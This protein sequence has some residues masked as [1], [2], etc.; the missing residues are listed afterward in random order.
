[1]GAA[2]LKDP[3]RLC[4]I[5]R[6]LVEE[7]GQEHEIGISVKIRLL[8]T[9]EQTRVL[10][11]R[12]VKTGI[13]ALTVHCR[14]TPMRPREKAIRDHLQ[15]IA[16]VC[17]EAG[18]ACVMNGDVE[19]REQAHTLMEE[20]GVDGAMIASAAEKNP[21]CFRVAEEGGLLDWRE[22]VDEYVRTALEVHNKW[23]NTKYLLGQMIPGK[24]S[25]YKLVTQCKS[26]EA[27]V[28]ALQMHALAEEA[29]QVDDA[30]QIRPNEPTAGRKK[31]ANDAVKRGK[32]AKR[33]KEDV[34]DARKAPSIGGEALGA[35]PPQT[36]PLE[37]SA[38]ALSA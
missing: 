11:E 20:Y 5:L 13:A 23:G 2:L 6:A 28:W 15:M 8:E 16:G 10:V 24:Q 35:S 21:S 3:D 38:A 7:V 26:Y 32:D 17:R 4:A 37:M 12:L 9:E 18:V 36:L 29:R 25:V 34:L 33:I 19:N 27:L 22:V 14:T 30:L 1:M 31:R